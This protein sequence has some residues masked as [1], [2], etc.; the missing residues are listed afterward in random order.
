MSDGTQGHSQA[1]VADAGGAAP[2]GPRD[3]RPG[4]HVL[5]WPLRK[6]LKRVQ[7]G[8]LVVTMPDGR[9]LEAAGPQPGPQAGLVLRRWRAVWRL[10][11]QGD[12]GLAL[13][14]RDGDWT[15][16]DLTALLLFGLANESAWGGA[17][18]GSRA[19]RWLARLLHRARAN[20][21]SGS[22][23]NIA[24][25]Y[26]LG[27]DFYARWLDDSMLYSSALYERDDDTLEAAQARRLERIL[28]LM[29][30]RPGAEVLEIGCGWGTLAATLAQRF[31]ARVT[32][33]TLSTEQ[34]AF[35]RARAEAWGV[36]QRTD[37]RLQDYRDVQGTYDRIV[38]I[39]MIEAVGEDYWPTYFRTLADRLRP[40]GVA[41]IQ[42]IT[43]ADAHF[44]SYRR[45]ADFIQHCIFPG[46]MLPSPSALREQAARAGLELGEELLFGTSYARTLADWR[47]RFLAAW[48]AIAAQ[49]FDPAFKRLWQYYLCYCEAGFLAGRVDVGLYT[50]RHRAA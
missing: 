41:V 2:T 21:R 50:L 25:H 31:D 12:L 9:R 28:E 34:L 6:L 33:L 29:R 37:L 26:D 19:G 39:E 3:A 35:A 1:A 48:P 18:S 15:S 10:L 13:S 32:G 5:Q 45:G 49:G 24:F 11:A 8:R 20:T 44:D 17:G 14:W 36:A 22:R 46:G 30:M 4:W 27:N 38:S 7:A 47:A 40:G 42:A 43:I 23:R 16:P